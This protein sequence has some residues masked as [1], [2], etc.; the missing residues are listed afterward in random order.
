MATTARNQITIVD[1]NDAKSV[2]VY[3]TSSQGF[4]QNYNPDTHVYA[5]VYTTS[6]NVIT[7]HVYETGDANDHL[8]RCTN[9]KYTINGAAYTASSSNASYVVGS[10][11]TLTVK[12]NLTGNLNVTF[13][14]DYTDEDNIVSKVGGSFVLMHNVSSG[15]LFQVVLTCPKGNIFDKSVSGNLTVTAQA[16]RGGVPDD[17]NVTYTWTQFDIGAGTWKN[18]ASGRASGKTLTVQP[19]DVLNF[20]TFKCV[21]KDAGGT[22]ATATAEAIVTFQ[23]LTDPY[24]VE[25]YCPTG[26][27]IVNGTGSTTVNA[28]VWQGGVKIEDETTAAASRKFNYSWTKFDKAGAA[29]NWNGTTSNVKTGNPITVLAAE[30]N[31]KTTIVCEITKK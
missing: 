19:A 4:A 26:D 31:V 23:D 27:K 29:Q 17:S 10:D 16:V 15:A 28:R 6:N 11:G 13:E 20:Q 14:T 18:V 22:D 12:V 25:L 9:V 21:A 3:F 24:V 5:P 1:L 7:P 2:Q 30:V 8:A